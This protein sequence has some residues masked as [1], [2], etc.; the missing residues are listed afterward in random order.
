M[1]MSEVINQ[2]I[3]GQFMREEKEDFLFQ[4]LA[5]A[6]VLIPLNIVLIVCLEYRFLRYLNGMVMPKYLRTGC[7]QELI[8]KNSVFLRARLIFSRFVCLLK[9]VK[10]LKG[11]L[12]HH[13]QDSSVSFLV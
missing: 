1:T 8:I 5:C 6:V 11:Q 10:I 13:T 2:R 9:C 4:L 12:L 7:L 3:D